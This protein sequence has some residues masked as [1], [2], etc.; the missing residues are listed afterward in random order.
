MIQE[1][2]FFYRDDNLKKLSK[3]VYKFDALITTYE[4]II[5]DAEVLQ[6]IPWKVEA[7]FQLLI[8]A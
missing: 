8:H 7:L 1:Y 3:Q 5:T 4:M 6:T 2:E